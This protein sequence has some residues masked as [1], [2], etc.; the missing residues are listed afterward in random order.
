MDKKRLKALLPSGVVEIVETCV[1]GAVA[2]FGIGTATATPAFASI[3]QLTASQTASTAQPAV[4]G[5]S[6]T[7]GAIMLHMVHTDSTTGEQIAQHYS[8]ASHASHSSHA[9]HYSSR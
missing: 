5:V 3:E 9:S 2:A 8:H 4:V 6:T 1:F 7:E